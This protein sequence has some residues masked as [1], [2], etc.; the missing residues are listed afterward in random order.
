MTTERMKNL[1]MIVIMTVTSL[2]AL[3]ILS[4][5]A[6]IA[7]NSHNELMAKVEG[8]EEEVQAIEAW[9][10]KP[11]DVNESLSQLTEELRART[12]DRYKGED[13][14]RF[15][16]EEFEALKAEVKQLKLQIEGTK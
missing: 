14:Q 4:R 3:A 1:G 7:V 13:F 15:H 8:I 5:A 10:V 2:G 12:E 11:K 9:P 6:T 16:R